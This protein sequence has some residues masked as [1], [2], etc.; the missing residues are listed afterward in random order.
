MAAKSQ[1]KILFGSALLVLLASAGWMALQSSK[2]ESIRSGDTATVPPKTYAAS[3]ADAS[4]AGSTDWPKAPAQPTGPEWIYNVFTPPEIYYSDTTKKFTVTPPDKL[5]VDPE[6]TKPIPFG[7]ELVQVKEDTF[8]LQLVGYVGEGAEARGNFENTL[9]GETVIGR[10]G[11]E[12]PSLGLKIKSFQVKR[13]RIESKDSM[14]VY[15]TEAT[16]VIVDMK[17]GEEVGLTN[18]RRY[19]T[20]TPL[21]V[22]KAD[23][24]A[25][26]S[27]HKA[28]S[29]FTV[30]GATYTVMAVTVTPPSAQ[31]VKESSELKEPETKTLTPSSSIAPVPTAQPAPEQ[32]ATPE[33]APATPFPFGT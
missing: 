1:D 17:S 20:G 12:I 4:L 22:V 15:D 33:S 13:N 27:E 19:I 29:K 7:L 2:L 14:P 21:A 23:G 25:E 16:A 31:I 8:R 9:T 18:K 11:K 3:G 5:I 10:A 26:T 6:P 32:S 30:G 28:G 24:S